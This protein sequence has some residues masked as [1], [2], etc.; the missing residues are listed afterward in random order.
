MKTKILVVYTG[1]TIGMMARDEE[2]SLVVS[3]LKEFK[4]YCLHS[5][6]DEA[7][8]DFISVAEVKDSSEMNSND[9]LEINSIIETN[10]LNYSAF[11]VLHGTD[12]MA[13]T[14]TAISF[15]QLKTQKPIVFTGS[16]KPISAKDSDAVSN[17]QGAIDM[18]EYITNS[19][20]ARQ[21][22]VCIYFNE[23]LYQAN[24]TTKTSTESIS[25]FDSPHR[26]AIGGKRGGAYW[27][28][29]VFL[30]VET[31]EEQTWEFNGFDN[32]VAL[33]KMHPAF[34]ADRFCTYL[35]NSSIK[36]LLIETYGSGNIPINETLLKCLKNKIKDG[37]LAL[38]VSQCIEGRVD[39]SLYQGGNA[40]RKVGV[41]EGKD[42]T[43]EAA[44]VKLMIACNVSEAQF[45]KSI[46][47]TSI[48]GEQ[49]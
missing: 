48:A 28:G 19:S 11:V 45:A 35:T 5:L 44:L 12:T 31:K 30:N 23:K 34:S 21:G 17:L 13:Y 24:R 16:Q 18:V 15:L 7:R 9:W 26:P 46:L 8:V 47:S 25:A 6:V 20:T 2:E 4:K 42:L 41:L 40:Y 29:N 37:M 32:E 22:Q 14:A 49:S 38:S 39:S 43:T 27:L 1:G 33:L 10:Y 3:Y 36:G